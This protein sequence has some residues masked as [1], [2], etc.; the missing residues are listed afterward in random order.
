MIYGR[1]IEMSEK[2]KRFNDGKPKLSYLMDAPNAL[3]GMTKVLEFGAVKY[4]RSNWKKGLPVTEVI[5]SLQRHILAYMNGENIDPESGLPHVDHM[6]CNTLFL[7]EYYRSC[8][9]C[10]N[11]PH[12]VNTQVK[13]NER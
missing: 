10:D 1:S 9:E 8:P 2:A 11:R 4:D 13:H 3:E 5:D 6:A 12:I 7:A